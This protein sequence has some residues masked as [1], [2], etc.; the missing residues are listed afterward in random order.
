MQRIYLDHA[1]TTPVRDE[2]RRAMEP[3]LAESFGNPS[4]I[5]GYG[6][7]AKSA[8]DNAR[9]IV[10]GALN[11]APSEVT[12]TSGGTEADNLALIGV[13]F[14]NRKRGARL[15]TSEIEHDAIRRA[16]DFLG[17]TGCDVVRLPV[18]RLGRVNVEQVEA[19]LDNNT[20]LVSI[21]H[22]NNEIGT[23]Q[24][25]E[26]IAELAHARGALMH[27]DAVQSFGQLAVTPDDLG[28]DLL[29]ISS[30]KIYGPKGVGALYVRSGVAIDPI[31]HGGGQER[32]RRS[33]TENVPGIVGFGEATRLMIET[34]S[35]DSVMMRS[36]RDWF[37]AELSRSIPSAVLNGP[38]MDRL[39]NNINISIPGIEGE[40]LLLNL[41]IHG[42]AAS[43]GSACASGSIEPSHVM[44]ALGVPQD[45]VRGALRLTLG[46]QTTRYEMQTT[47]DALI[48]ITSRLSG[49]ATHNLAH[50]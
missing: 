43:S 44:I 8:L 35:R 24:P 46:R 45:R 14:A 20:V 49:M 25:I 37:I 27:T 41:D 7:E 22:A 33:G 47:L 38:T 26:E 31:L 29:S 15:I 13:M 2:V 3:Y 48:T 19:A 6:Q 36:L 40:P 39:P 4:S 28:V 42:I 12:F 32:E 9:D 21:M 1:A 34:R 23:I 18:D 17:R 30:H 5:H 50:L 16:A 10:S 11:C